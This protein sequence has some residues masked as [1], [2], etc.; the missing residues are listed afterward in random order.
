MNCIVWIFLGL[1]I[2]HDFACR[3]Q[4]CARFGF[5]PR[6][7]EPNRRFGSR[8]SRKFFGGWVRFQIIF[9]RL[10]GSVPENFS[11]V[12]FG[13]G[14]RNEFDGS[15]LVRFESKFLGLFYT[16]WIKYRFSE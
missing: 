10:V 5:E 8:G 6:T 3:G 4:W 11:T 2:E 9:W 13:S 16:K 15:G 14:S 7:V 12:R 1:E